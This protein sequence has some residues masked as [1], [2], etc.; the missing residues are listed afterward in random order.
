MRWIIW[1]V[2]AVAV[3]ALVFAAWVRLAPSDPAAWHRL[4]EP[5]EGSGE[6]TGAN[7]IVIHDR[8]AGDP[9]AA[10]AAIDAAARATPR[11]RVLAG[12]VEAGMIT[13]VTRSRLWAF[14]DYTTVAVAPAGAA[15]DPVLTLWARSRFG[16][17]DLGVNAARARDW[18]SALAEG[19][20]AP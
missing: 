18:M 4:P 3:F 9:A 16:Q 2:L 10:L 19:M 17:S 15:G 8:L 1:I 6:R 12:S 11:T 7:W 5:A 20:L 14:P 13:Y